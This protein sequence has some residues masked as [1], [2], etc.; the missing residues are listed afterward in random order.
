MQY[1]NL[2]RDQACE[3]LFMSFPV[4]MT[5]YSTVDSPPSTVT[6]GDKSYKVFDGYGSRIRDIEYPQSNPPFNTIRNNVPD[7][8]T[9]YFKNGLSMTVQCATTLGQTTNLRVGSQILSAGSNQSASAE[10]PAKCFCMGIAYQG[11]QYIGFTQWFS[12]SISVIIPTF[13][14][15]EAFWKEAF[16]PNYDYG[17]GTDRDGG[18]GSGRIPH[19]DIPLSTTPGRVIPLGG[20]GLH[21]YRINAAAYA[22]LQGYLWGESSTLAKSLWQKFSNK[23][24]NPVSCIVG[25]FS[26]PETFMPT[27]SSSTGISLA[28]LYLSPIDGTC[29]SLSGVIGFVDHEITFGRIDPPFGSWLD[30]SGVTAQLHVPFCGT[31]PIA[32][33][34][35]LGSDLVV[36]Y[37]VDQMNGNVV[38]TVK[39]NGCVIGEISGN[40]AYSV[41][42]SGGDDGTLQRLGAVATG[43]IA[44]ASSN[45]A[46]VLAASSA[47]LNA[48]YHTS[49][50]NSDLR[51]STTAC[52]NRVPYLVWEYPGTQYTVDY[53]NANGLPC[54][55]SGNLSAFSG[56]YG[57][58]VV[59]ASS[60]ALQAAFDVLGATEQ[61]KQEIIELLRSGVYV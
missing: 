3:N 5:G 24:H 55:F 8:T 19:T 53:A 38:A 16:R 43:A 17:E 31:I 21:A 36:R 9:M 30:Y 11:K 1:L 28:G 49:L 52:E 41:P 15:E 26:L 56:G 27:S 34:Q 13:F 18:Q 57:E 42:V 51:G 20:R 48:E 14:A 25:C 40:C 46:G 37:R 39:A 2:Y 35:I 29:V 22:S 61:E 12:G 6:I 45:P 44:I 23:T 32:A 4:I 60:E 7:A 59:M 47:G 50:I 58:F 10:N 54:Q 33:E